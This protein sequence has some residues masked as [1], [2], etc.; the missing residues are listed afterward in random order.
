M[1]LFAARIGVSVP[2][3]RDLE[4]GAP[5]VQVGAWMNALWAL[6]RL[7]DVGAVLAE[8]ESLLERA[9]AERRPARQRAYRKRAARV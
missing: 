9:R 7:D 6:D 3:L 1:A 4:R 5:S 8:R 2:T